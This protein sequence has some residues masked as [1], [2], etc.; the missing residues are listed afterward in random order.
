MEYAET[1]YVFLVDVDFV[2]SMNL[3]E[4]LEVTALK[5]FDPLTTYGDRSESSRGERRCFIVPAFE[6]KEGRDPL[7]NTKGDLLSLWGQGYVQPFRH[8]IWT[9]GH[10]ATDYAK[11]KEIS[12]PYEFLCGSVKVG[13]HQK[14]GTRTRCAR[15]EIFGISRTLRATEQLIQ[16]TYF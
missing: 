9:A 11:W 4:S 16:F 5:R 3:S 7:P 6:I 2:P 14:S 8:E 1:D 12:E 15:T 10:T 13:L